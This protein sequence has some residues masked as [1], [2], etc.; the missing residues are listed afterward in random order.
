MITILRIVFWTIDKI[1]I[2][3]II[4]RCWCGLAISEHSEHAQ[5]TPSHGLYPTSKEAEKDAPEEIKENGI[6]YSPNRKGSLLPQGSWLHDIYKKCDNLVILLLC[7][8]YEKML[9][10]F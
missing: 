4:I 9:I 1:T 3:P 7:G 6:G 5:T 2:I 10:T 8:K